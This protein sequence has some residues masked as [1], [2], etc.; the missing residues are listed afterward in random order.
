MK[1]PLVSI[2]VTCY[3]YEKYVGEAIESALRQTYKN[4]EVIVID[5]GST[6]NSL[7]VINRFNSK[8]RVISR[9]NK[10]I[11]YTRNEALRVAK[12]DFLCF[13]DADDYFDNDYIEKMLVVAQRHNADIVY[14][15]WR[16]FGDEE[17][18]KE[19]KDFDLQ[20]LIEQQI[21]CTSES[22]I[23]LS[24]V[25]DSQFESETVAEDW[26]FFLGL[27]LK[28]RSFK[29]APNCYINYRVKANSRGSAREY[30]QDMYFFCGILDKWHRLYPELVNP[31]DLPIRV[32][33][34]KQEFIEEQAKVIQHLKNQNE[35]LINREENYRI[36]ANA[37]Q[38]DIQHIK[39]SR[40]YKLGRRLTQTART[41]IRKKR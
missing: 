28:G 12:G 36:Q 30:W 24:G 22:L 1:Q 2:V 19:F 17:Y 38:E 40:S 20:L 31:Y 14:P 37:L 13:L 3:N 33:R 9:K 18:I 25:G 10:G 4:L 27:A 15:N 16:V 23:R 11:V 8:L 39:S 21:H 32:I 35:E 6:D 26:D 34:H 29:Y 7:E 5:D 41:V